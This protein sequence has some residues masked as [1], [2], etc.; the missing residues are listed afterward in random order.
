MSPQLCCAPTFGLW[1]E[2][3][4]S[5]ARQFDQ[6]IACPPF[7]AGAFVRGVIMIFDLNN[8]IRLS[9]ARSRPTSGWLT[10]ARTALPEVRAGQNSPNTSA[11]SGMFGLLVSRHVGSN[12]LF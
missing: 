12:R 6:R 10:S 4:R 1:S 9:V 11:G 3:A 8:A 5:F 7:V 2:S